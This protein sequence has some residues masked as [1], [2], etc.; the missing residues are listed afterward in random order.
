MDI[1]IVKQLGLP[2][3][4]AQ[5]YLTLLQ[6]GPSSVRQISG[7]TG[8]N[9]GTTYDVL[10][11]MQELELVDFYKKDSKQQF[12]TTSPRRLMDLHQKKKMQLVR[13]ESALESAM[14]ELEA[15]HDAGGGGPVAKYFPSGKLHSIL[16][17]VLATCEVHKEQSYRIYSVEGLR[18]SLYKQFPTFS[19]VRIAK[20]ISVKA[21]AIGDG[22]ELRGLDERK[23]L[24][25]SGSNNPDVPTYI[26]MYPGKTAYISLDEHE[27][28]VGVVIENE[29]VYTTQRYIFDALWKTI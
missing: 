26:I 19:D 12:V 21:I 23:W 7:Y 11:Q 20:G 6:K 13:L 10:K 2:E 17:D 4:S 18:K 24:A 5:V 14:P 3:K 16:E 28:P 25:P 22:G 29:G 15:L 27:E 1:S 8:I 9:R